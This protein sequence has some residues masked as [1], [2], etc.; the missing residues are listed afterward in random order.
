MIWT[1]HTAT[2]GTFRKVD[3]G[4]NIIANTAWMSSCRKAMPTHYVQSTSKMH[5]IGTWSAQTSGDTEGDASYTLVLHRSRPALGALYWWS[6][7]V[8]VGAATAA[9]AAALTSAC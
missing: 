3:E 8:L 2:C 7:G 6:G 4:T 5:Y 9:A 1:C